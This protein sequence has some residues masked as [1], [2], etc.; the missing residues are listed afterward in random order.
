MRQRN[1]SGKIRAQRKTFPPSR[2]VFE[3]IFETQNADKQQKK[4][5]KKKKGETRVKKLCHFYEHIY[6]IYTTMCD[7]AVAQNVQIEETIISC[8][9]KAEFRV[10]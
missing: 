2:A 7:A 8:V 10:Y 1:D 3:E 6:H 5:E 4:T 9:K